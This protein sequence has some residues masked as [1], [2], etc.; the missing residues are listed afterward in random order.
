MPEHFL[1][2]FLH[3]R[4]AVETRFFHGMLP[5]PFSTAEIDDGLVLGAAVELDAWV[6]VGFL[7]GGLLRF[8]VGEG[9]VVM[10]RWSVVMSIE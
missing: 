8:E 2:D 7:N 10:W 4:Q 5:L 9:P 3:A 1:L 6:D